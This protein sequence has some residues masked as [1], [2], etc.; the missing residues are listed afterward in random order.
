MEYNL[1]QKEVMFQKLVQIVEKC[2][3]VVIILDLVVAVFFIKW[4]L[5][6][7]MYQEKKELVKK[8]KSGNG[9]STKSKWNS[10]CK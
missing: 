9:K 3:Q 4:N 2:M 1:K 7:W 10:N 6:V 8:K 5:L